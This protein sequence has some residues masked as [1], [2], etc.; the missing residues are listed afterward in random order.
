MHQ[1]EVLL[2]NLH[3]DGGSL[4]IPSVMEVDKKATADLSTTWRKGSAI[5]VFF[6][7]R[8]TAIVLC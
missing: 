2:M 6:Y 3:L 1:F 4:A 7:C 8:P 5:M